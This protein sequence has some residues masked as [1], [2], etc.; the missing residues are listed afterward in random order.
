MALAV[1]LYSGTFR[2][3]RDGYSQIAQGSEL[4]DP[5]LFNQVL[6]R[7]MVDRMP[8]ASK[9][10]ARK[11]APAAKAKKPAAKPKAASKPK[12]AAKPK[13]AK[14]EKAGSEAEKAD[15]KKE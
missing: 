12:A 6:A 7:V 11:S 8:P 5:V 10:A 14:T 13:A 3:G 4:T 9:P 15:S 1:L 2:D